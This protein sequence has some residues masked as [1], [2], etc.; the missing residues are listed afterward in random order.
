MTSLGSPEIGYKA[1]SKI[2]IFGI[3]SGKWSNNLHAQSHEFE[4]SA[5]DGAYVSMRTKICINGKRK[6]RKRL[7]P[8]KAK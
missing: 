6:Y 4:N 1:K 7:N 5:R 8:S 3:M 2:Q